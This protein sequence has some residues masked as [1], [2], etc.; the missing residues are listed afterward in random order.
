MLL[1]ENETT[2]NVKDH[3]YIFQLPVLCLWIYVIFY[4]DVVSNLHK[5][6]KNKGKNSY[7]PIVERNLVLKIFMV[8]L[9][10]LHGKRDIADV[11]KITNWLIFKK[12][13]YPGSS[14]W[15]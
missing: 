6:G 5:G 2:K 14:K 3:D 8:M 4:F 12:G 11:I 7:E 1:G 13:D 9:H 10:Y 15:G